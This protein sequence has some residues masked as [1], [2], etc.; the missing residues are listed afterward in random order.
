MPKRQPTTLDEFVEMIK[1]IPGADERALPF[2]ETI[3]TLR[4]TL[5]TYEK[6]VSSWLQDAI[7]TGIAESPLLWVST[8][9]HG[10]PCWV[11][12]F[13]Y[14]QPGPRDMQW[15][16][17]EEAGL[18]DVGIKFGHGGKQVF[19]MG[20]RGTG[21]RW[22]ILRSTYE[23]MVAKAGVHNQQ[24]REEVQEKHL[25]LRR[26]FNEKYPDV[27]PY[28]LGLMHSCGVRINPFTVRTML[29]D[30]DDRWYLSLEFNDDQIAKLGAILREAGI[31]PRRPKWL[32]TAE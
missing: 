10:F 9:E 3:E 17:L 5:R 12:A 30:V 22:L 1:E 15:K 7:C 20:E 31:E 26:A 24:A 32:S 8:S 16:S 25:A 14:P 13:K 6:N 23:A 18:A 19:G 11:L 21:G 29:D 4:T 27:L 28:L 2:R